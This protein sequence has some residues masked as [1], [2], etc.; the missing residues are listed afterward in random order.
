MTNLTTFTNR[1]AM[2]LN[3]FT[4]NTAVRATAKNIEATIQNEYE[5]IINHNKAN[6]ENINEDALWF[7]AYQ[8]GNVP[9][10]KV[11]QAEW[12]VSTIATLKAV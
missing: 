9:S 1:L 3:T 2:R 4:D 12:L 8:A 5:I 11:K 7:L 10:T 6:N